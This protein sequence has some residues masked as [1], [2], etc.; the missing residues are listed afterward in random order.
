MTPEIVKDKYEELK[1][2]KKSEVFLLSLYDENTV[3]SLGEYLRKQF[4]AEKVIPI[5]VIEQEQG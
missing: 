2:L 3:K 4:I 5:T 1:S